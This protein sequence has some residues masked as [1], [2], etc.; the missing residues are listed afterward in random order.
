MDIRIF[1]S[2]YVCVVPID[3]SWLVERNLA[4]KQG[5]C[6]NAGFIL[7]RCSL[8]TAN[9]GRSGLSG[10]S[11]WAI[12]TLYANKC[13]RFW[14]NPCTVVR[15]T[16]SCS[17]DAWRMALPGLLWNAMR[18]S[19]TSSSE[20]LRRVLQTVS[21]HSQS[22]KTCQTRPWWFPCQTHHLH[23]PADSFVAP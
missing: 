9:S 18:I 13:S 11:S 5:A 16:Y 3:F 15:G 7:I 14:S 8:S 6:K 10:F 4:T 1:R 22:L 12:Y 23:T 2:P 20:T 17:L 19:S 21:V